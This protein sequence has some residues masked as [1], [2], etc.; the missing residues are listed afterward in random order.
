M[1]RWLNRPEYR[2]LVRESAVW[3]A[4]PAL[5]DSDHSTALIVLAMALR[6]SVETIP[7]RK[8][9]NP[10]RAEVIVVLAYLR[11]IVELPGL[12]RVDTVWSWGDLEHLA[13]EMVAADPDRASYW[14][15]HRGANEPQRAIRSA[16][17]PWLAPRPKN[18]IGWSGLAL[19]GV[20]I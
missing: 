12:A 4:W 18:L 3:R 16:P 11:G 17:T 14:R 13:A 8:L 15:S 10:D 20:A 2:Q 6:G 19:A 5:R 1:L 7:G 9:P